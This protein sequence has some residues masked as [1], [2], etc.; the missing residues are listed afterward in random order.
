VIDYNNFN[1]INNNLFSYYYK[2]G[3]NIYNS[4]DK[5]FT[6]KCYQNTKL[7]YDLTIKKR[8]ILYIKEKYQLILVK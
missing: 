6:N 8:N 1:G 4:N 7:N 3:I 5:I 2:K